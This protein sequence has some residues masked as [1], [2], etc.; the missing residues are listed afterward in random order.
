MSTGALKCS[1]ILHDTSA[2][3]T[4]TRQ[5]RC[6]QRGPED[7]LRI[8]GQAHTHQWSTGPADESCSGVSRHS[9][10]CNPPGRG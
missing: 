9:P 2:W 5:A 7:C 4:A 1:K 8:V 10:L 6:L 3:S